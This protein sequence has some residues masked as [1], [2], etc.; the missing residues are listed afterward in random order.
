MSPILRTLALAAALLAPAVTGASAQSNV[1]TGSLASS[2]SRLEGGEYYDEYTLEVDVGRE[3]IA[4]LSAVDFDPFLLVFDPA[5]EQYQND[6]YADSPNVALVQEVA[7][8]AGTWR[9]RVTSYEADQTG[10]YALVL[11]TRERTDAREASERFTVTGEVPAGPTATITGTL[12]E[13]DPVRGDGSYYEGWA[14]DVAMGDHVVLTLSSPDFDAYL[15]F[16]SPDDRTFDD[17][18]GAGSTNSRVEVVVDVPGRWIV[19]ANT[20]RAGD[21]GGYTLTVER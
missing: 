16:A 19:V 18:D 20:L 14:L 5:G 3:V 15:T 13:G 11:D 2:D 7:G 8:E 17:D 10:D 21:T 4:I 1:R 6:D 12:E 9:I